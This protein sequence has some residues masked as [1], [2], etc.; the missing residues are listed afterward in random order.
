MGIESST[1][2]PDDFDGIIAGAPGVDFNNLVSARARYYTITGNNSSPNFITGAL[3]KS[4]NDE[5]LSQCDDIDG[6][7]D[8]IIEDPN[9]CKFNPDTL[10][11]PPG[12]TVNCLN[13][14][15]V[16][17]V[18]RMFTEFRYPVTNKLIYPAMQP[19][20]EILSA[21]R[22]YAGLPFAYSEVRLDSVNCF[23]R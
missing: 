14:A 13:S 21:T 20:S 4:I 8:R 17:I 2:F 16:A 23:S 10:L 15:Q 1:R 9:K 19:G 22:L 6:V 5:I 3:W 7:T 18:R 12:T 11:C